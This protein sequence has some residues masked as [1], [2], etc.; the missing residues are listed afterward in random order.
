MLVWWFSAS[1]WVAVLT[2]RIALPPANIELCFFLMVGVVGMLFYR[3]LLFI[4]QKRAVAYFG[5]IGI[6]LAEQLFTSFREPFSIPALL[7]AMGY[8]SIFM[9]VAPMERAA[10]FR[11]MRSFVGVATFIAFM[12]YVDWVFNLTHHHLPSMDKII[13]ES[14]VFLHYVYEQPVH[15]LSPYTKP[16][17][18]FMLEASH[19]SQMIAMGII[20]EFCTRQNL[21]RLAFLGIALLATYAG[22]G[23]LLLVLCTPFLLTRVKSSTL[24]IALMVGPLVLG[25]AFAKGLLNDYTRRQTEFGEQGA[26]ANQRFVWP[27]QLA[28][29]QLNGDIHDAYLG[30]GASNSSY[31]SRLPVF[32][33]GKPN[34][35]PAYGTPTK[36]I[37]EFGIF[38]AAIWSAYFW[39]ILARGAVP[40][41]IILMMFVQ[42]E[43]LNGG[44]LVPIE[45]FYC[46]LMCAA[47]VRPDPS[48]AVSQ[49]L[50]DHPSQLGK[51][52]IVPAE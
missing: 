7:A 16:N 19:T 20:V 41:P 21:L 28:W 27:Y 31:D 33:K 6:V 45:I 11:I 25:G 42:Y 13:P 22:T 37:I 47:Y 9:F 3:R 51:P 5:L 26:S 40:L 15:W 43:F 36:L 29:K 52:A 38:V 48:W 32:I 49:R 24:M 44:L 50:K 1:L 46:Y 2:Q 39:I 23:L 8:Y 18:F 35:A 34:G 4:E 30:I 14:F 12:V 10:I 17:A